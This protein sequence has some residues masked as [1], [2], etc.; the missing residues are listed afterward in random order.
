MLKWGV[1][2]QVGPEGE[3]VEVYFSSTFNEA[4]L[5]CHTQSASCRGDCGEAQVLSLWPA[6]HCQDHAALLWLMSF[7]EPEGQVTR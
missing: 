3:K 6:L 4:P 7:R 1:L 2:A 5:Q